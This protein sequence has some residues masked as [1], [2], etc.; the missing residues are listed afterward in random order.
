MKFLREIFDEQSSHNI[1]S[2]AI[3]WCSYASF[4]LELDAAT[5]IDVPLTLIEWA[6][7]LRHASQRPDSFRDDRGGVAEL[8]TR[9]RS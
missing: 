2:I 1:E 8:D 7:E 9:R 6:C 4:W 5:T 3:R